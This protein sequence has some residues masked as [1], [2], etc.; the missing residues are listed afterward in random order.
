MFAIPSF[1][2]RSQ[3][4]IRLLFRVA[5]LFLLAGSFTSTFAAPMVTVSFQDGVN[6]YTGAQD[7]K[8]MSA[9]PATVN[10]T[11]SK[12]EIDGSPDI[13]SLLYWDLTSIPPGSAIQSVDI[14]VNITNTSSE[15]YEFYQLLQPWVESEATWNAYASGQSWQVAGAAGSGDRGS[16]VLGYITAPSKGLVTISLNSEGVAVVQSWVDN[17]SSN[18]GLIIQDYINASNGLDFNSRETGTVTNRPKMT[19][20]YDSDSQP[21][22]T[23]NDVTFTE[24]NSGETDVIFTI[25]LSFADSDPV[26]VDYYTENGSATTA[27]NDYT[28]A[29]GQI[30]FQPGETSQQVTIVVNGD[31]FEEPDIYRQ[32]QQCG[33]CRHWGQSRHR[34]HFR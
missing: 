32:S 4:M 2:F 11:A 3:I 26:T 29:S 8:L 20:T 33:Q 1:I 30:Y 24:G 25:S 12:L 22:L 21:V 15:S 18:Y 6:G 7:T 27:D 16:T 34:N 28:A 5:L 31:T 23:I 19:V 13:S 17:P 9:S 10:G 14:M